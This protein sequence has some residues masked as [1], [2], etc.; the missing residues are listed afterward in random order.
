MAE[1]DLATKYLE[2]YNDVFADIVNVLLYRG[3]QIVLA[4]QLTEAGTESQYKSDGQVHQQTRDIAKYW[5]AP[6]SL[7]ERLNI[8]IS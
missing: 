1:K 7:Y 6:T 2:D 5:D 3:K 4:E 8:P